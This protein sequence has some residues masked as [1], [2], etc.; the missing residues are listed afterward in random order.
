MSF[1]AEPTI[2]VTGGTGF[3]GSHLLEALAARGYQNLHTTSFGSKLNLP[4]VQV[5]T[6][7]VD[8]TQADAV[9]KLL[10]TIRPTHIYHLASFAVVG[11]SF[12]KAESILQNNISLQFNLLE[13]IR[14]ICPDARVLTIGSAEE[15]GNVLQGNPSAISE[16]APLNPINP[17]AVSKVSQDLL[18]GSY[19]LAHKLNIV[20]ARPFNHIGE[21]QSPDFAIPS[22]A[23]QIVA[24]E[25]GH[26]HSLTVGNLQ[27]VRDFTDVKD[28]VQAYMLL[29]EHGQIGEVYN[30][31]S[32]RGYTISEVLE[33][34]C[35]LAST[36]ITVTSDAAKLRPLDVPVTVADNRKIAALGW[37][38]TI[39]LE[40]TLLRILNYWR[41]LD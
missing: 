31:G 6:H 39:P 41:S 40:Q 22:F 16:T 24:I 18:A 5:Q 8:L 35:S 27:A 14:T 17:Y 2:L 3:A 20:R 36:H 1:E 9:R 37:Q 30:I 25:R 32:G 38:P 7:T 26:Q 11:S 13:S 34:L 4:T 29:M 10:E 15:Y 33:K 21:R 12:D 23:K 28:M 19:F